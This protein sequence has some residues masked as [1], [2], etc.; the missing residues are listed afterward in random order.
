MVSVTL[1]YY[2]TRSIIKV[3]GQSA[4]KLEG[5]ATYKRVYYFFHEATQSSPNKLILLFFLIPMCCEI[6]ISSHHLTINE[7]MRQLVG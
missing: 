2:I 3:S 5:G 4:C 7:T 1:S 6:I